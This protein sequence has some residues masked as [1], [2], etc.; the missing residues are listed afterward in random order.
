MKNN[1]DLA[2]VVG[3]SHERLARVDIH[4]TTDVAVGTLDVHAGSV[5]G[6]A[7]E[8]DRW[9]ATLEV[10]G[11]QWIPDGP[12]HPLSGLSRAWL[13]IWAGATVDTRP[14]LIPVARVIPTGTRV[15]QT[16]DG[17][18][19]TVDA[20]G[21][22]GWLQS[23][24]GTWTPTAGETCQT[25]IKRVVAA[26]DPPSWLGVTLDTTTAVAVPADY[27]GNQNAWATIEDLAAFADIWVYFDAYSRL[28]L[29]RPLPVTPRAR[30]RAAPVADITTGTNLVGYDAQ[31]GRTLGF[32]N[33]VEIT[34]E[35]LNPDQAP[36]VGRATHTSGPLGTT[37]V[38]PVLHTETRRGRPT[39][40]QADA[41]AATLLR[42]TLLAWRTTSADIVPDPRLEPDDVLTLTLPDRVEKVRATVVEIPLNADAAMRV[43]LRSYD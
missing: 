19:I 10:S 7:L 22:A 30:T 16:T 38:G 4:D 41:R 14:V 37:L 11:P 6:S 33:T 9:S 32:A 12:G 23:A 43:G 39:Q 13:R 1:P 35:S 28:V 40:A 2:R 17:V 21:P 31:M 24:S 20:V 34:F 36:R 15:Q 26:T 42:A 29:R 25:M 5:T 8:E 3:T 27:E 18:T